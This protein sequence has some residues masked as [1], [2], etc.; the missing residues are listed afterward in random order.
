MTKNLHI[1]KL[2]IPGSVSTM[3][4][5][6]ARGRAMNRHLCPCG[7]RAHGGDD[8]ALTVDC[9]L[10]HFTSLAEDRIVEQF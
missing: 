2:A 10:Q 9:C 8:E 1:L 3:V 7:F 4:D 6:T 5:I